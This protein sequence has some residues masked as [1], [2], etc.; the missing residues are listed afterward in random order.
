MYSWVSGAHK[1]FRA[2]L[3]VQLIVSIVI[4]L[5][6]GEL[7]IA[8]WLGLPIILL[9]LYLSFTNPESEISGHAMGIGTQLMTALHIHQAFGLIE[10]HFEI[11]ALLAILAYFRNWKIIASATV[12]IAV[13]HISFFFLQATGVGIYV[14]EE[15]HVTFMI[16]L[17]HAVF[18]LVEGFTLMYMTKRS[19]EDGVGGA[20]LATA[21]NAILQDSQHI[22]LRTEVDKSIPMLKRF[23]ELMTALRQLVH[24][25]SSLANDVASTSAFIQSSTQELNQHVQQSSNE[26]GSISAASEEIAVT[27]QDSSERTNSANNITQEAR[28]TTGESRASVESAK[29]TINSLRDRLNNTANTNQE[30]NERCSSISEAMRSIT[31]VA[32]QTNLLAL[33]A[34]IE[35]ARAG[36]HGRGFA[37][38]ADEVRTLAIRS[39]E[40]ADEITTITEQLVSST[41]S[42]VTQMN[43]CI[44]LVDEAVSASDSA[45]SFMHN[46]EAR[47]QSA[48]DNMVE[49]AASA[50]EQKVASSNIAQG[51]AKIHELA[52][53]ES[54]TAQQLEAKSTELAQM[55]QRMLQTVQRFVV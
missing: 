55:C 32:E 17:L 22:N 51:T 53:L 5:I 6:T 47:I 50:S 29:N 31:A 26:I 46:I 34:A 52:N 7:L 14:F 19:Y 12:V 48:S 41:A 11:F 38:V 23:D 54:K 3:I 21:I 33:N 1:I 28:Q 35:S 43:Q 16:L 39:K 40:S 37:V 2:I 36:E 45:A 9:P 15:G 10:M 20:A 27:L 25:A 24:D 18:A 8:F 42:S 49:V 30:L 13:H 44:E 4:G